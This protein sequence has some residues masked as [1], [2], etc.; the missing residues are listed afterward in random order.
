MNRVAFV[1]LITA[2]VFWNIAAG[3]PYANHARLEL[4]AVDA[5]AI[6]PPF[7]L[8]LAHACHGRDAKGE[9]IRTAGGCSDAC[10]SNYNQCMRACD[11]A[12]S[13]SEQCKRNYEG[14]M[15]GCKD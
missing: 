6:R 1:L 14:C 4:S 9:R 13:C 8:A 11:G 15:D 12:R 7:C 5:H 10:R 2:G 3:E